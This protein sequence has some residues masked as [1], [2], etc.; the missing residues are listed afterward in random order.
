MP[1]EMGIFVFIVVAILIALGIY[2]SYQQQ[3][4]RRQ[5]L[6]ALADRLG[7]SFD[8]DH[9][10]GHDDRFGQFAA[11]QRGHSRYAYNTLCGNLTVG[12]GVWPAQMGDYHYKVTSSNGK[13]TT[14]HTYVFSYL[15]IHV[16]YVVTP[17]LSIRRE[18]L[19]DKLAG[20]FGF[21]DIDFESEEFSR[22]FHVKSDNKRFAYDVLHPRMME[23]MLSSDPPGI[24]IEAGACC[25][26]DGGATWSPEEFHRRFEWA[27]EFFGLWPRHVTADLESRRA[28]E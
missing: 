28:I 13:S 16:P 8:P 3:L 2:W 12:D 22:R 26:M 11:F 25:V 20:A 27:K 18:G 24:E 10:A 19:F 23:F 14:T 21:D 7:W 9:D 5:E 17:S 6:A 15:I 1:P 4:R